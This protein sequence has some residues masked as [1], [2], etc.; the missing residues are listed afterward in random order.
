[1]DRFINVLKSSVSK[2]IIAPILAICTFICTEI[3][4]VHPGVV[5]YIYSQGIY[6]YIAKVL[7][8]LSR[9]MPFS[10]D[11]TFYAL[12]VVW[13]SVILA[14]VLFKRISAKKFLLYL[15]STLSFIYVAFYWLWGFNYYRNDL[16]KRLSLEIATADSTDLM[17]VF[18]HIIDECN[19]SYSILDSSDYLY[20][21][22]MIELEYYKQADYLQIDED[23]CNVQVKN[24]T[25]S[26]FFAAA[27]I[28]GYYGP[29]FS[30]VHLNTYLLTVEYPV[31]LAHEMAHQLG[32]T[33][34]SE[35]NFYAWYVCSQ[36]VD[37]RIQY[38]GH[39]HLFAYFLPQVYSLDGV[40]EA[41][42]LLRP[43][44][45]SD[46]RRHIQHWRSLMRKDV[47]DIA[48]K[49]NDAYLKTNKVE[50][51]IADYDGVIKHVM[52]YYRTVKK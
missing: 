18:M 14:L 1:M 43:E 38:S 41:L 29:F 37:I 4:A 46:Y 25:L 6:P 33:D 10:I 20:Y 17:H 30:E 11:D 19:R 49:V 35:A 47:E 26:R 9:I 32:I 34:E 48:H 7:S 2:S 22:E 15:I 3:A 16:E 39:L 40:E 8:T 31:I 50:G 36:C 27:T 44:V 13:L 28:G 51:G 12:L 23:L 21:Q 45:K 42:A 24:I 52:N 5:E